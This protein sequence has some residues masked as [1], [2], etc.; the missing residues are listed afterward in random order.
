MS[1]YK[2][3]TGE[4]F[5]FHIFTYKFRNIKLIFLGLNGWF[6]ISST[7]FNYN[8]KKM[9][10]LNETI[11]NLKHVQVYV[12]FL[13]L[14]FYFKIFAKF[15]RL[16]SKSFVIAQQYFANLFFVL[17]FHENVNLNI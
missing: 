4:S 17:S 10:L 13:S 6:H 14:L 2:F 11:I 9:L 7:G 16:F 1:I 12:Y 15:K 8:K 3:K 5:F